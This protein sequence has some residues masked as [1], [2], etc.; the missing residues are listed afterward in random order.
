M[1]RQLERFE[2][3]VALFLTRA[4]EKGDKPFLWAKRDGA[5]RSIS[6]AEAARQ[7]AALAFSLKRIGLQP[8]DRVALVSENRPE[9]LIADLGIMA[10]GCVTVPTY[11]T[12][13]IRDHAHILGNSGARAV[14]VSNQKLAKNLV[15]AVLTST[16]CHH[17]VGIEDIRAGQVPDWVNVHRWIDMVAGA[18]DLADLRASIARAGRN[19][20]ACIIY[21]SGT[22]GA[23]RGVQQHHGMILHNVEAC[24]DI[25]STDFGWGDEVFLSFLPA[26]HAYEHT[27]GQHFPVALG[28]QIYYA[29][30]LEKLAA[31]IEEVHPTIMVVVPRLFEMLRSRIIKTIEGSGGLSKYLL[32]RALKI[33]GDKYAGRFKPW[34]MPM[35][36]ILGLTLRRKIREKVGGR[37]GLGFRRRAAKPGS[38]HLFRIPRD[39]LPSGVRPDGGGAAD[40]L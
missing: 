14:I 15:P 1:A 28:A 8:G 9:W 17:I 6:W 38:R 7:V 25:I 23:P 10:A 30:S 34:D 12:N 36:G 2:N 37:E 32:H 11:T 29:E 22:G 26:S 20:L 19:D 21:T 13:T 40:Q 27:G 3:L 18:P 31:N 39:H 16:E 33:G 35:D 24:T 5:W 4:E